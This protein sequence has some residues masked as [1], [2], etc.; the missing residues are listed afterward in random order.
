MKYVTKVNYNIQSPYHILRPMDELNR[1][2]LNPLLKSHFGEQIDKM[3]KKSGESSFSDLFKPYVQL[4]EY[5]S[6]DDTSW[7]GIFEIEFVYRKWKPSRECYKIFKGDPLDMKPRFT[8]TLSGMHSALKLWQLGL[9]Y[10]SKNIFDY[11]LIN[12]IKA[13]F[14]K[15]SFIDTVEEVDPDDPNTVYLFLRR[16][17]KNMLRLPN[18]SG[19]ADDIDLDV[20]KEQPNDLSDN[21]QGYMKYFKVEGKKPL[22]FIVPWP[23]PGSKKMVYPPRI[24]DFPPEG[25]YEIPNEIYITFQKENRKNLDIDDGN[26]D[27]SEYEKEFERYFQN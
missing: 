7:S 21:V 1:R 16:N 2:V 14:T 6:D 20:Y 9:P 8:V 27:Y 4:K 11:K 10:W 22:W 15:D 18:S 23:K 13:Y 5:E 25:A 12:E 24:P 19:N 17:I 3:V 26:I